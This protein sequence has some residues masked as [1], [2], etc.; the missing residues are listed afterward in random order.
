M[1]NFSSF[2]ST[3]TT[4]GVRL[5]QVRSHT[6]ASLTAHT[7]TLRWSMVRNRITRLLCPLTRH[8][9]RPKSFFQ[10]DTGS[11]GGTWMNRP[12]GKYGWWKPRSGS[13]TC[14]TCTAAAN[15]TPCASLHRRNN[16]LLYAANAVGEAAGHGMGRRVT[17]M[18][19]VVHHASS[20]QTSWTRLFPQP[21]SRAAQ[22]RLSQHT[23][24]AGGTVVHACKHDGAMVP[25]AMARR[26]CVPNS[27]AVSL[28][29]RHCVPWFSASN[30]ARSYTFQNMETQQFCTRGTPPRQPSKPSGCSVSVN[31]REGRAKKMPSFTADADAVSP[32]PP[33][34][35]WST[36][37]QLHTR[38]QSSAPLL[39]CAWR[40]R[41]A[42]KC[43]GACRTWAWTGSVEIPGQFG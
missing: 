41:W 6:G 37:A 19:R 34:T 29:S 26:L 16:P 31:D 21:Q 43:G 7:H 35:A 3:A 13:N 12:I 33:P 1:Q 42:C 11:A 14:F 39:C 24:H 22:V 32:A 20:R 2:C 18:G 10:L 8:H 28:C 15:D 4:R 17:F 9:G 38:R 30:G 25:A 27:P 5:T 40:P 36:L 23:I